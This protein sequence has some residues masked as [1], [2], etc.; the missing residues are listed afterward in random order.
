MTHKISDPIKRVIG[1]FRV[2]AEKQE[3]NCSLK[4]QAELYQR[5]RER[6]GWVYT[7]PI[8]DIGSGSS[9]QKRSGMKR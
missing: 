5:D 1:Y 8:Q 7:H 4:M 6:N 3:G 2:A 9:I